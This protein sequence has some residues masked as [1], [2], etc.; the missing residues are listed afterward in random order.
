MRETLAA[1]VAFDT[2]SDR[3]NLELIDYVEE[4]LRAGGLATRRVGEQGGKVNLVA[5]L[6]PD[7]SG[8][9]LLAGHTDVVP[10]EDQPWTSDP[11]TLVENDGRLQGR[12]TA[13][14]KGALAVTIEAVTR[15]A[16]AA[17]ERPVHLA[18]TYDEEAGCG[19]ARKLATEMADWTHKPAFAL[20]GEPT[21]QRV[22]VGHKGLRIVRTLVTGRSAH[23]SR[24]AQGA[25]AI[26]GASRLLARIRE[27]LPGQ[28]DGAFDPP[29]TTFSVG[30]I[31]G[32]TATNVVP[33]RCELTWEVRP[34][35]EVP[36][37]EL[38]ALTD[39]PA[40]L[41]AGFEVRH[42]LLARVPALIPSGN[43]AAADRVGALLGDERRETRA[44]VTEGGLYAAAGI[45]AVVCGPGRLDQAHRP[46]ESVAVAALEAHA[47]LVEALITSCQRGAPA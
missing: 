5:R 25:N 38:D 8:G 35:P 3:P 28:R 17:F 33:E 41:G 2:V 44:F 47:A 12:G 19:G 13:D 16:D 9:V 30:T 22:V 45:P 15:L 37:A 4:R 7:A 36:E 1:L 14:M 46:D 20:L 24:P 40:D 42:E 10:V 23:A 6:G 21:E 34:L 43:A 27:R 26:L 18:F 29:G 11:F 39:G 31:H 32:G